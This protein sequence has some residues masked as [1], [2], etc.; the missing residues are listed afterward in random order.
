[1]NLFAFCRDFG[2][3]V[4]RACAELQHKI[5]VFLKKN[6]ALCHDMTSEITTFVP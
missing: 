5:P 4:L 6:V 1:M 2:A 3:K